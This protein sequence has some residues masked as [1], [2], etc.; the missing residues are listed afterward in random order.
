M[1][2]NLIKDEFNRDR[3]LWTEIILNRINFYYDLELRRKE[4]E[5]QTVLF[6][7]TTAIAFLA[8]VFTSSYN[9][10]KSTIIIFLLAALFGF[11]RIFASL[12]VDKKQIPLALNWE[13]DL[14]SIPQ[15]LAVEIY[16]DALNGQVD[17]EKIKKYLSI[18]DE[19]SKRIA[20]RNAEKQKSLTNKFLTVISFAFLL[21]FALGFLSLACKIIYCLWFFQ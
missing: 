10:S 12:I 21:L 13:T 16:G 9:V 8:I 2:T 15:K 1:D 4:R 17:E 5:F 11:V 18:R 20:D 6:L 19:T 7:T 14:Y 3:N